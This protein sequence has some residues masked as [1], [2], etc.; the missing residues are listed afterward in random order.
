SR[1][2]RQRLTEA[3]HSNAFDLVHA[4]SLDLADYFPALGDLPIVCV[5]HDVQ[6]ALLR[7]RAAIERRGWR[8]AYLRYQARLT[9]DAERRW[10]GHIALNVAV[11]ERDAAALTAIAPSARVAV[12]P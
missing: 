1:P 4:D 3:L 11:S 10:C 2:F 5:H 7:R 8:R 12:V 9:E 6:S